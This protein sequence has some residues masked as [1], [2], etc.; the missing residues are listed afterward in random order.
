M[1]GLRRAVLR[2]LYWP[3]SFA[4]T[5]GFVGI[6]DSLSPPTAG[7]MLPSWQLALLI[8]AFGVMGCATIVLAGATDS[9]ADAETAPPLGFRIWVWITH[10]GFFVGVVAGFV[11]GAAL[12]MSQ[13]NV[14]VLMFFAGLAVTVIGIAG[15]LLREG[16]VRRRQRRVGGP[17]AVIS[18][19]QHKRPSSPGTAR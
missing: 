12:W 13:T 3:F 2:G 18:P 1:T 9:E 7:P 10:G 6:F 5:L 8:G 14:V 11:L 17:P 16:L 15:M 19:R 4:F